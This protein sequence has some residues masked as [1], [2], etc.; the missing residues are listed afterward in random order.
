MYSESPNSLTQSAFRRLGEI[1]TDPW[2]FIALTV[3][4]VLPKHRERY[5]R[6]LNMEMVINNIEPSLSVSRLPVSSC[7]L[8]KYFVL[9]T[10]GFSREWWT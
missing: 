4:T 5:A 8:L 10:P 6:S 2:A 1:R 3:I 7:H 9:D